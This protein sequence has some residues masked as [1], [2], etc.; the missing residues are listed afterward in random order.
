M[1]IS[2]RTPQRCLE[3]FSK[4]PNPIFAGRLH[5]HR[6][7]RADSVQSG[8][9]CL[10]TA[11]EYATATFQTKPQN[12]APGQ[13]PNSTR[14]S[15][16]SVANKWSG[17]I[18]SSG[19]K[20]ALRAEAQQMQQQKEMASIKNAE[21]DPD[22]TAQH[23][24]RAEALRPGIDIYQ[25]PPI[26]DVVV[27]VRNDLPWGL[28]A[29]K[30]IRDNA[31]NHV[32]SA[33]SVYML[34][35]NAP[36]PPLYSVP[37]FPYKPG[38]SP[39]MSAAPKTIRWYN[40][41]HL[42]QMMRFSS[43]SPS[44]WLAG[45]PGLSLHLYLQMC[46][47]MAENDR[48]TLKRVTCSAQHDHALSVLNGRDPN[49]VYKWKF[50]KENSPTRIVSFRVAEFYMARRDPQFGLD[51]MLIH[52]MIRFDTTQSLEITN[53]K[54]PKDLRSGKPSTVVGND[55]KVTQKR[56]LEY[57]IVQK[58]GWVHAPWRIRE[59]IY[60][61][62]GLAEKLHGDGDSRR[63]VDDGPVSRLSGIMRYLRRRVGW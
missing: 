34:G 16:G 3:L 54:T 37:D 59:R 11:R 31:I 46:Q 52:A 39:P 55:S 22:F 29:I 61:T 13:L 28:N 60:D 24:S 30:Y 19:L 8:P 2:S 44:A 12:A 41:M 5:T 33:I 42:A 4:Y 35:V 10:F 48:A 27:P 62:S 26:L 18:S 53:K 43:T 7:P 15:K 23:I 56:V 21:E 1:L 6:Q 40:P 32:K 36:F 58:K 51:R 50:I 17:K 57:Y 47:A 49:L 38:V 14:A 63:N 20:Q 25:M 45:I 9:S